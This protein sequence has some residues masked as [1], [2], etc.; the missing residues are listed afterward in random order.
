MR[1]LIILLSKLLYYFE[2]IFGRDTSLPGKIALKLDNMILRKIKLP[3]NIIIVTGSNGKSSTVEMINA[4]LINAGFSVGCNLD[5]SN[6][7]EKITTMILK[8]ANLNGVI[9]KDVLL[10][11][12]DEEN[13]ALLLQYIKPKYLVIT[14]LFRNQL[15]KYGHP[16]NIFNSISK[17][18]TQDIQLILNADDPLSALLGFKRDKVIFFGINKTNLSKKENTSMYLDGKYCPNCKELMHYD[19]FHFHH[20][21]GYQ[22]KKCGFSRKSPHYAITSLD[23]KKNQ[24]VINKKHNISTKIE[25]IIHAYNILATYAIARVFGVDDNYI[26][27]VLT[28]NSFEDKYKQQIKINGQDAICL[29]AKDEN[30]V[31]YE[32]ALKYIAEQKEDCTVA[33]I[34]DRLCEKDNKKDT[35][36]I[37]DTNFEML[38]TQFVKKIIVVGEYAN[39]LAMRLQ[40]TSIEINKVK[41]VADITKMKSMLKEESIGKVFIISCLVDKANLISGR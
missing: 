33:L 27:R 17:A 34:L 10:L 29:L 25:S 15:T 23:L 30:P 20:I 19:Y 9:K 16:E 12:C 21:G 13:I 32:Q 7:I 31:S 14:N 6:K 18:L 1:F 37:W 22:C 11:E 36:W 5:T 41:I 39:D 8:N 26:I 3:D 28:N 4:V 24:M 2:K 40:D 35:S 38:N